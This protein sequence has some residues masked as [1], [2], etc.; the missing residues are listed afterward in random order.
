MMAYMYVHVVCMYIDI[1]M[2]VHAHARASNM[3]TCSD[4][5]SIA[6]RAVSRIVRNR[7]QNVNDLKPPTG[8]CLA[9]ALPGT[10]AHDDDS[11]PLVAPLFL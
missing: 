4:E 10:S 11:I 2:Y 3:C 8:R 7:Y 9:S 5:S 6:G 1:F